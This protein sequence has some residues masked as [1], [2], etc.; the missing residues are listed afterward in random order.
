MEH[1]TAKKIPVVLIA[2]I[3]H[4]LSD[5]DQLDLVVLLSRPEFEV[6]GFILDQMRTEWGE[7][8]HST[9]YVEKIFKLLEKEEIPIIKGVGREMQSAD[10]VSDHRDSE[11]SIVF[12]RNMMEKQEGLRVFCWSSL[13]DIVIAY[14]GASE[15][16]RA[17][18]HRVYANIGWFKYSLYPEYEQTRAQRECNVMYDKIAFMEAFTC[19]MPLAWLP[20]N[21]GAWKLSFGK[22]SENLAGP[23]IKWLDHE[24]CHYHL[25]RELKG[26]RRGGRTRYFVTIR[27][28]MYNPKHSPVPEPLGDPVREL[29]AMDRD[30][31]YLRPIRMYETQSTYHA[32]C[33]ATGVKASGIKAQYYSVNFTEVDGVPYLEHFEKST[34]G[35]MILTDT[36][37][38]VMYNFVFESLKIARGVKEI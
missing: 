10:D 18:L 2:D 14:K 11:A 20:C 31:V 17:N 12:L 4:E 27:E 35:T 25:I 6:K 37:T 38:D 5:F 15:K 13:T 28:E 21:E 3:Y 30:D 29:E 36:D 8:S 1:N 24:L 16:V 9:K 34:D 32:V 26:K 33:E 22:V 23:T 7:K 19:G